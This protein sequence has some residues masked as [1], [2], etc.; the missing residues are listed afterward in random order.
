MLYYSI[1]IVAYQINKTYRSRAMCRKAK[2]ERFDESAPFS[3]IFYAIPNF[4][5]IS[6]TRFA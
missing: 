3:P 2:K 6:S 1:E 4:F 5:L